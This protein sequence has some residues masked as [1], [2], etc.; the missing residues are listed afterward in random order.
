MSEGGEVVVPGRAGAGLASRPVYPID[1]QQG[2]RWPATGHHLTG[3]VPGEL[4]KLRDSLH[5]LHTFSFCVLVRR[6]RIFHA[7]CSSPDAV[8]IDLPVA[9]RGVRGLLCLGGRDPLD[10][11]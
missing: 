1:P 10:D 11:E 7:R 4:T 6:S 9:C 3:G 8:N 2:P 5:F